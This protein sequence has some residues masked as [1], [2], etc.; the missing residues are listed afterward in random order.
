MFLRQFA[1]NVDKFPKKCYTK[2]IDYNCQLST[3]NCYGGVFM[4][5]PECGGEISENEVFCPGCGAELFSVSE[6]PAEQDVFDVLEETETE[7]AGNTKKKKSKNKDK[8]NSSPKGKKHKLIIG[9]RIAGIAVLLAII[10][11]LVFVAAGNISAAKGRKI[12][13]NVDLGRD[14]D[15]IRSK[16]KADFLEGKVSS[17]GAVNHISDY[18]FI[19]ESEKSVNVDGIQLPEWAVL[20]KSDG[21]G[22]V[23][24]AVLY[25]FSVLKHGWMGTRTA[26]RLEPSTV[27]FGMTAKAAERALG[28]KPYT[29]IKES[30]ENTS[31]YVYR[32][33]YTDTDSG[34]TCVRNFYVEVSDVDGKV[35]S[36]YDGQLDYLNLILGNSADDSAN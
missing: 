36:A 8:G 4:R 5:C 9:I 3:F 10:A 27:E 24:E 28:L 21:D 13:D 19:C 20:L 11:L 25:N 18:N 15:I 26:E 17:Y 23:N 29:I 30:K 33:N 7:S 14:A 34:N 1:L 12:F 31:L 16:T 32:Y 2:C 6:K 35:K 22:S